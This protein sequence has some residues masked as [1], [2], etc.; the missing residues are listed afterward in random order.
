MDK[1]DL[2][3]SV[4]RTAYSYRVN[5]VLYI[6]QVAGAYERY[7]TKVLSEGIIREKRY[8]FWKVEAFFI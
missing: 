7:R 1:L 4:M 3:R 6:P 2:F 5:D 8:E